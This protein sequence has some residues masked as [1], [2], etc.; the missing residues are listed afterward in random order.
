V[1]SID[2]DHNLI[3]TDGM[4][5]FS[6]SCWFKSVVVSVVFTRLRVQGSVFRRLLRQSKV[7][8]CVPPVVTVSRAMMMLV[9]GRVVS[10]NHDA[11]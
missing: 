9:I 3:C 2:A 5:E 6:V 1:P 8:G 11:R 10:M 7:I 4:I